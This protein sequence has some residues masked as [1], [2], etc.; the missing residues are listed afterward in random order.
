M[1]LASFKDLEKLKERFITFVRG[2]VMVL[3][4]TFNSFVGIPLVPVAF[5]EFKVFVIDCTSS[6]SGRC[7]K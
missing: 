1:T 4:K 2:T 7:Q 6:G 5:S 3:S